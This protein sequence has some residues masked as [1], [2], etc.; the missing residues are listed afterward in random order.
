LRLQAVMTAFVGDIARPF[1]Y[2]AGAR[3]MVGGVTSMLG[4]I[5]VAD[6]DLRSEEFYGY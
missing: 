6:S 1:Y 5:A 3:S 2:L 4:Q